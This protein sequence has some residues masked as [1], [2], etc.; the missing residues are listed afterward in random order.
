MGIGANTT[1]L[2][3]RLNGSGTPA[4]SPE[5]NLTQQQQWLRFRRPILPQKAHERL[6]DAYFHKRKHKVELHEF[7]YKQY[8]DF[9]ERVIREY[10]FLWNKTQDGMHLNRD[11]LMKD[12]VTTVFTQ[13]RPKEYLPHRGDLSKA[14]ET[15]QPFIEKTLD[16][17]PGVAA[18]GSAKWVAKRI[19]END[20]TF[21]Q[22]ARYPKLMSHFIQSMKDK[23]DKHGS[24]IVLAGAYLACLNLSRVVAVMIT[25]RAR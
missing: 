22:C 15:V 18:A 25:A 9:L 6:Q 7:S 13:L 20:Y 5:K 3:I 21:E 24:P 12:A 1:R 2:A 17:P 10:L 8:Y 16:I 11:T 23:G 4:T 14:V 19:E